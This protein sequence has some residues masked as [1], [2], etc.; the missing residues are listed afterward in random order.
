MLSTFRTNR[1]RTAA[2]PD[3]EMQQAEVCWRYRMG[4]VER[5]DRAQARLLP[6]SSLLYMKFGY[7][8]ALAA[9]AKRSNR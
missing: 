6:T 4:F 9:A 8:R 7:A 2:C 3:G 1:R 5:T